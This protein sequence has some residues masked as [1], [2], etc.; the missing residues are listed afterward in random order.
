MKRVIKENIN[1]DPWKSEGGDSLKAQFDREDR[2]KQLKNIRPYIRPNDVI[3][4]FGIGGG[5]EIRAM[6]DAG[7]ENV[8]DACDYFQDVLEFAVHP[9]RGLGL[10]RAFK[11]DARTDFKI[12]HYDLILCLELI[13]HMDEPLEL[14]RKLR[15]FCD[16]L[17][18]TCPNG[19]HMAHPQHIWE[20][21]KKDLEIDDGKVKL[22]SVGSKNDHILAFY[23]NKV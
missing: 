19:S 1:P 17:V 12:P 11:I 21:N 4:D 9:D 5:R 7:M 23:D 18:V 20:I 14:I 3:L 8:V 6:R 15:K 10:R 16:R 13:E 2:V 22:I